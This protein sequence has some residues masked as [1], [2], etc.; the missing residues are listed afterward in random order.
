[1]SA[2]LAPLAPPAPSAAE[3]GLAPAA[4]HPP[5]TIARPVEGGALHRLELEANHAAGLLAWRLRRIG[6]PGLAGIAMIIAALALVLAGNLPQRQA[7]AA[8]RSQLAASP[9]HA[10][11]DDATGAAAPLV[12]LPRREEVPALLDKLL[13][14]ARS[15]GVE[16]PRGQYEFLPAR[17]AI[18]A[19]YS[20]TF[21]IHSSYPRL[22]EF[23]DR[24]LLALPAVAVEGL[25][26]ERKDVGSDGVDA[27]LK[28]SVF[29]RS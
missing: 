15:T 10:P 6:V 29:V 22:R 24:S 28:L 27:E 26:I 12:T 20:M 7:V 8:L 19:R 11:A 21:P 3:T 4:P 16:L 17:D 5:L 23:M 18:A 1:M 13:E 2:S 14:E 25:R 9:V